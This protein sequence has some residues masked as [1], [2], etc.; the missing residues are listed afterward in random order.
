MRSL[1]R[2]SLLIHFVL[3]FA[4]GSS[5]AEPVR[6]SVTAFGTEAEIEVRD[7]PREVALAAARDAL[8]EIFEI[9]QL[10]EPSGEMPGSIGALNAAAGNG[11]LV[12]EARTAELLRRGLQFCWWTNGAHGPLGGELY[13][14]WDPSVPERLPEPSELRDAVISAACS[15]LSLELVE[16]GIRAKVAAGTRV[17]ARGMQ[18]GFALD[19]AVEVLRAAG[20]ANAWLEI[21]G[22][23]RAMGGGLDGRGWLVD[24]PPA[25]GST[26]P[27]DQVW[28]LDQAMAVATAKP[29]DKWASVRFID[30]RTGVPARGVL[31][32]ARVTERAV[33]AE[34][35]AATL[36][37]T[38]LREGHMR[39]GGLT[40]RPSVYWLLGQGKGEPLQSTYRWSALNRV[41]KRYR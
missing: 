34:A 6:L 41:K 4:A 18:R 33:D 8:R 13:L 24:L 19:A 15:Q 17:A 11:P 35:L 29:F 14:L 3:A 10:S 30:Q 26:E 16:A 37:V 20:V 9:S 21:G 1:L 12:L 40:P 39:L 28:L 2:P 27:S 5:L 38:G 31:M 23:Y 32:V 22:V 36:Y 25:P 7:L